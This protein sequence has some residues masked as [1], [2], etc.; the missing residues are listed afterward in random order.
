MCEDLPELTPEE[1]EAM[2][3]GRLYVDLQFRYVKLRDENERLQ[4]ERDE[5][6][7]LIQHILYTLDMDTSLPVD[8]DELRGRLERVQQAERE[9]RQ[10]AKWETLG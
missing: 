6:R 8:V 10:D 7:A 2:S 4:R 5:A 3:L 1:H 9:R